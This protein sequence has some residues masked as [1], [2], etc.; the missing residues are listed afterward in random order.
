[1][2]RCRYHGLHDDRLQMIADF[3]GFLDQFS[4]RERIGEPIQ[5]AQRER[6]TAWLGRS[7]IL[8]LLGKQDYQSQDYR[9]NQRLVHI[10]RSSIGTREECNRALQIPQ[11]YQVCNRID[12]DSTVI[13]SLHIEALQYRFCLAGLLR[14]EQQL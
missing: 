3:L 11:A 1:M 12:L 14:L 10:R 9:V 6:L 5:M 8:L 4:G 13:R 7:A 2:T